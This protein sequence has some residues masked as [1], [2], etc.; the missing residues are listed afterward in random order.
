MK[1]FTSLKNLIFLIFYKISI[2]FLGK[3]SGDNGGNVTITAA[4]QKNIC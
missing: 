1:Y 3:A 4:R 2:H